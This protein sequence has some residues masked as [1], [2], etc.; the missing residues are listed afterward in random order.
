MPKIKDKNEMFLT[1]IQ[2]LYDVEKQLEK[3]LPKLQKAASDLEL[4]DGFA[5]HLEETKNHSARLEKIF[6]LLGSAPKKLGSDGIKG[7]IKDGKWVIDVDAPPELKDKMLA[8][9]ARHAEHYEM[10]GY[11]TAII[12]ADELGLAEASDLLAETLAEEEAA[13]ENLAKALRK[14]RE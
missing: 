1:K 9:A 11:M 7:I 14:D 2:V 4:K 13:D 10:S 6:E 5:M 3:A 8:G 12:Q